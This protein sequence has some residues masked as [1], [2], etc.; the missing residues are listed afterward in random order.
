MTNAADKPAQVDARPA[1]YRRPHVNLDRLVRSILLELALLRWF[2]TAGGMTMK[3]QGGS[4]APRCP[5]K[6][7]TNMSDEN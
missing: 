1:S 5:K 7:K 4:L 6:W 3:A 2:A